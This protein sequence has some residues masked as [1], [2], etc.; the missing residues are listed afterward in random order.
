MPN[1][2]RNAEKRSADLKPA[3]DFTSL[4]HQRTWDKDLVLWVGTEASLLTKLGT[5]HHVDLD[6]LDL[7]DP[8][9]LPMDDDETKSQLVHSLRQKLQSLS[10]GPGRRIVLVVKSI[11]LLAR[12]DAGVRE[13]YEWFCGDFGM[14]VL[15][16]DGAAEDL[17]WPE[18]VTCAPDRLNQYFTQPGV[19][20]E[21]FGEK[22]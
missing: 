17:E 7:F 12:Y 1:A 10:P 3:A 21:A 19:V 2:V 20:K 4:V 22:G 5:V 13:F 14:V 11:G 6:L 8:N 9:H 16:L 15:L 18:D